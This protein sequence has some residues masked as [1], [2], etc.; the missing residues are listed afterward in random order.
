MIY[1]LSPVEGRPIY[2]MFIFFAIVAIG[3]WYASW[4][5]EEQKYGLFTHGF[6]AV[7]T[8]AILAV[9]FYSKENYHPPK[10]EKVVGELVDNYEALVREK[11]GK[12][13]YS[14]VPYSFVIYR[15]PDG[16]QVSFKRESGRVYHQRIYLYGN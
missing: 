10:N 13:T 15:L 6:F 5:D 2:I 11:T 16:G 4:K 12:A 9:A 8:S 7:V 14:D 1:T 3:V